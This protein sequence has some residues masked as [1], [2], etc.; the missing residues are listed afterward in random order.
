MIS[1]KLDLYHSMEIFKKCYR[2][3]LQNLIS[4]VLS[5]SIVW[6][7]F[8]WNGNILEILWKYSGNRASIMWKEAQFFQWIRDPLT[9]SLAFHC[10]SRH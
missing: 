10:L 4:I 2:K 8:P 5:N 7:C 9:L 3:R 6:K 1:G